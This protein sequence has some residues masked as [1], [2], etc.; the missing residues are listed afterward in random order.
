MVLWSVSVKLE[1]FTAQ[2]STLKQFT[3]E[4]KNLV[5]WQFYVFDI[6][7]LQED[8]SNVV[9]INVAVMQRFRNKFQDHLLCSKVSNDKK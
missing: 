3:E 4:E 6:N 1:Y 9:V 5:Y 7:F 8:I 2:I